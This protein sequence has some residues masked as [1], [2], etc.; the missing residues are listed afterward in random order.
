[1]QYLV[2]KVTP[3]GGGT[4]NLGEVG[5]GPKDT[6][7]GYYPREAHAIESAKRAATQNPGTQYAVFTIKHI[8]E[9]GKP[10][11]IEKA[12]NDAG[13]IVVVSK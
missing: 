6:V 7:K 5:V 10:V 8:F 13:E 3:D 1:M 12:V 4:V 2:M 9:T 11:F